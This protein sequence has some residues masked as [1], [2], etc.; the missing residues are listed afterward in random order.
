MSVVPSRHFPDWLAEIKASLAVTTYQANKIFFLGLRNGQLGL[1]ERTMPRVMGIAATN[2]TLWVASLNS[3]FRFENCLAP[4]ELDGQSDAKY[5]PQMAYFTSDIDVHDLAVESSGRVVFANTLY[6]CLATLDERTGFRPLWKPPF[7]SQLAA[8]DRCHL[9]GLALEDGKAAYVT[10]VSRSD[11]ADG[12]RDRRR[13]GGCIIDVRTNEIIATGLSM[14][15]SPRIRDGRLWCLEA[16]SG[17]LCHVDRKTGEVERVLFVP[18][19]ARG[20]T[21]VDRYAVICTSRPREGKNFDDFELGELLHRK[22]AEPRCALQIVD[23]E[24]GDIAHWFRLE[25]SVSE[26]FDVTA[27]PGIVCPHLVGFMSKEINHAHTHTDWGA[28]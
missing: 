16:G 3:I 26:L 28:L 19:Y 7:V 5:L 18:G 10:T 15:H 21:F 1:L 24:T 11:V 4:G 9:N 6:S 8:E 25:G 2:E 23:L 13:D 20:M 14:P 22:D 17:H 27:I 12:W